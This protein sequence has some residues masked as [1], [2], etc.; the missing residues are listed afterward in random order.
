LADRSWQR[1]SRKRLAA[2]A[3]RLAGLLERA[4]WTSPGGTDLFRWVPG[5]EAAERHRLLA[6]HGLWTRLFDDPPGLRIGLPGS[7]AGW[8]RLE[9]VIAR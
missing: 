4:G 3:R 1:A 2:D 5:A 9:G 8:A 6:E 7:E